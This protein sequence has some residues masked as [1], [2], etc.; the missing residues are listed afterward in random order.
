M[1][2]L[3]KE[4]L[5]S[6]EGRVEAVLLQLFA[7]KSLES[8]IG[9]AILLGHR[10]FGCVDLSTDDQASLDGVFLK[11]TDVIKFQI[12]RCAF[13]LDVSK[14]I[15]RNE[16]DRIFTRRFLVPPDKPRFAGGVFVVAKS[17]T[18]E[19]HQTIK[20]MAVVCAGGLCGLILYRRFLS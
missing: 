14:C 1:E 2:G 20:P 13:R 6:V 19:V 16:K 8:K 18:E 5:R 15:I 3:E 9:Y 11:T 4:L 17:F 10:E 7:H 12:L